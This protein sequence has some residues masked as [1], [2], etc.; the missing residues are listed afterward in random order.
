MRI[1]EG[2][3]DRIL[4]DVEAGVRRALAT[5]L[6]ACPSLP[7]K[8]AIAVA[9]DM[10]YAVT[11]KIE[12]A[13]LLVD[14]DVLAL[15]VHTSAPAG[16][17]TRRATR[18]PEI[19]VRLAENHAA[20][21]GELPMHLIVQTGLPAGRLLVPVTVAQRIADWLCDRLRRRLICHHALPSAIVE[22]VVGNS[23]EQVLAELIASAHGQAGSGALAERLHRG[24]RLTATLLLRALFYGDVKF[25][26]AGLAARAG[27]P[28]S[29]A[30]AMVRN[31][32][33]QA[34]KTVCRLAG[35]PPALYRAFGA[36]IDSAFDGV[37]AGG[38]ATD[39]RSREDRLVGR[40]IAEYQDLG[41]QSLEAIL[42]RLCAFA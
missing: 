1:A 33:R 22:Q 4:R 9:R 21:A 41:P 15:A 40:L 6:E 16:R 14:H 19:V 42:S 35:L 7:S 20:P 18:V 11:P 12:L 26:E 38:F 31:Q 10:A 8:P 39:R 23:S 2:L 25:F 27:V 34:H 5:Q 17:S 29:Y 36:G 32:G 37:T 13:Q 3:F 28:L 24:G 30:R